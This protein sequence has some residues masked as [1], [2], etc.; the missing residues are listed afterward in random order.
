MWHDPLAQGV[1]IFIP[2]ASRVAAQNCH[3]FGGLENDEAS[4]R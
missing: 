1:A 3:R 2:A 4:R